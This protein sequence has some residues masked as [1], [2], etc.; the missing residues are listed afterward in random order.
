MRAAAILGIVL[1][2]STVYAE[3]PILAVADI[4]DTVATATAKV[5]RNRAAGTATIVAWIEHTDVSASAKLVRD[6]LAARSLKVIEDFSQDGRTTITVEATSRARATIAIADDGGSI[7]VID[8]PANTK[9]PGRCV[10]VPSVTHEV[11]VNAGGVN[12]SGEYNQSTRRQRV[13]TMRMHDVDGDGILDAFVPVPPSKDACPEEM[14]WRVYAMRGACGHDVGVIGPGWAPRNA[15]EVPL[16]ASG[17][18]PLTVSSESTKNGKRAIPDMTTLTRTY[19]VIKGRY[20]KTS[21][22]SRTGVCHHCARWYCSAV[23]P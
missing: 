13:G 12:D 22:S 9:A 5:D 21:E 16:D 11:D 7:T 6:G 1:A 14:M 15:D 17:F 4:L 19:A 8:R 2:T 18:R 3:P 20:A 10:A 23:P